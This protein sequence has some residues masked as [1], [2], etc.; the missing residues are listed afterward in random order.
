MQLDGSAVKTAG[1]IRNLALTLHA[2]PSFAIHQDIHVIDLLPHFTICLS[3]D[4]I[5]K[6]GGFLSSDWSHLFF[7]TRYGMKVTIK[8]EPL[9]KD[10]IKPYSPS[11]INT[12]LYATSAMEEQTMTSDCSTQEDYISLDEWAAKDHEL[13]PFQ[14]TDEV[15]LG[16]Y[17]IRESNCDMPNLCKEDEPFSGKDSELWK[18]YFDGSRSS[19]GVEGGAILISLEGDKYYLACRFSFSCSNNT[20]EYEALVHGLEWARK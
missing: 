10:H 12:N 20:T 4:F 3:W 15:G 8:S 9:T 11:P 13:D 19:V 17:M 16:V 18:I 1:I 14:N 6:L 2:S 7:R 5:A